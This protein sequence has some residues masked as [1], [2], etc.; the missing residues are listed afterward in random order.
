MQELF[1]ILESL[2]PSTVKELIATVG[3]IYS[4]YL[5]HRVLMVIVSMRQNGQEKKRDKDSSGSS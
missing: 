4:I 3:L 5:T 2:S 1:R